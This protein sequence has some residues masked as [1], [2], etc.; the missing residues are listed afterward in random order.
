MIEGL[1][2]P[3]KK[4]FKLEYETVINVLDNL[5]PAEVGEWFIGIAEYE[6]YGVI[7]DKFSDRA[8][9]MAYRQT[10]REL[11][12]Q[13]EK[14]ERN[15]ER[16][17]ENNPPKGSKA[18]DPA[19]EEGEPTNLEDVLTDTDLLALEEQF[20][21]VSVLIDAV[22]AQIDANGTQVRYPR[23]YI[24]RY[25]TETKWNEMC[26]LNED[27]VANGQLPDSWDIQF[28]SI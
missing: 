21:Y 19:V 20:S 18:S 16:G 3:K 7:P 4:Y 12:Y 1:R 2:A 6:L 26:E 25:A 5:E 24:E 23:R 9:Q 27:L 17:R 8:V 28:N 14:H 13:M 11:D 22:Q 10:A 15:R